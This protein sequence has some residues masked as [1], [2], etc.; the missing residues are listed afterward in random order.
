[1]NVLVTGGSGFIG[2]ALIRHLI[3]NTDYHVCNFDKLTYAATLSSLD[4][5][6]GSSR[7]RFVQ[8]DI[9]DRGLVDRVLADFRPTV[10][11][12]LAAESHVD[13]SID[14][15]DDFIWTNVIGTFTLL[16]AALHYWRG[17]D[18]AERQT[19]RFH[20]VSTGEVYGS[21][22]DHGHFAERSAYDPRSPYSA[23]KASSDHLVR[24]WWHAYR[25]PTLITN[26]SNNYG[27]F[28]FPEQ[29]I[30]LM[31]LRALAGVSLPIY[32]NGSNIRDW[33]FVDDHARALHCVFEKGVPG[34]TYN[35]G[36]NS[37]RRII[38]VV[39][40]VCSALDTLKCRPDGHH[41]QLIAFVSG[42]TGHDQRSATDASKLRH[43]LGWVPHVDFEQGIASTVRWYLAN[44]DW[45]APL[46]A[47]SPTQ[48]L[49]L[50]A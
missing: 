22:P 12:H 3:A 1:M 28:Q 8:G 17:L 15:P 38:D 50:V 29:L 49:V 2:S 39:E 19:F 32:G 25:L 4:S 9:C 42:Q 41:R 26:C 21:L 35:I 20:H 30:P 18:A 47:G 27:P 33:L 5:V 7:Y 44:Q 36:G 24:T 10:I 23:S 34:E 48:R 43:Q 31:I 16:Q 40:T 46:L 45:W 13:R 14:V 11:V 37:E 6:E